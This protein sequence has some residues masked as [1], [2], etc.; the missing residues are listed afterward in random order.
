MVCS[1]VRVSNCDS[2]TTTPYHFS[3][4]S[5][6]L[7]ANRIDTTQ[8]SNSHIGQSFN[9]RR[10]NLP[11][12]LLDDLTDESGALA[13]VALGARDTGLDNAGGG[14]LYGGKKTNKCQR[15]S[16]AA[17]VCSHLAEEGKAEGSRDPPR[18]ETVTAHT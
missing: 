9:P 11:S 13:Q 10:R 4:S 18:G 6:L 12:N 2:N 17:K 15:P 7:G 14:L 16:S 1:T 5:Q 3:V 8:S